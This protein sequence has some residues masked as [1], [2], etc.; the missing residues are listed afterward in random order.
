MKTLLS[1][2]DI[3]KVYKLG[4]TEIHALCDV[5][6]NIQKGEMI[7]VM[8]PSG[9]GKS[10][11]I[12]IAGLLDRP[13]TG[14]VYL[15]GKRVDKFDD[16]KKAKIR[17][18]EIGFIFQQFNLLP[19]IASWENVALPLIY[20]GDKSAER[21]TKAKKMMDL[22]GLEDRLHHSRSQLSGGE[23]QRVA[24]A[25]ALVNNPSII[26]ADEPTGNL[27]SKSGKQIMELLKNLNHEGR[28]I[29]L[30]THELEVTKYAKRKIRL[31]DG[32]IVSDSLKSKTSKNYLGKK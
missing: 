29:V 21:F 20:A 7:A 24:I 26:F 30:V 23:Q 31:K 10:T 3:C 22:V 13:T 14:K 2:S 5:N 11:F 27:D 18:R 16:I 1:I 9:S 28:T 25:R 15:K 32:A 17:N 12:Q 19:K 6:L 8:G 4:E